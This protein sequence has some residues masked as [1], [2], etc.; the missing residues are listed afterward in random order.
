M[1]MH[2]IRKNIASTTATNSG[3]LAKEALLPGSIMK[4]AKRQYL[5]GKDSL[6]H[7][8]N[9]EPILAEIVKEQ[10]KLPGPAWFIA[11]GYSSVESAMRKSHGGILAVR[12]KLRSLGILKDTL[13][14]S[15][16]SIQLKSVI[17][18]FFRE[19]KLETDEHAAD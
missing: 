7:W 1:N 3:E 4:K 11:N 16:K 2:A 6:R 19:N 5:G 17:N 14:E 9:I 8:E 18:S 12:A 13:T 15:E 10:G